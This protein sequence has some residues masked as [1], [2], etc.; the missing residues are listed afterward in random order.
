[1]EKAMNFFRKVQ[2][3]HGAWG[4]EAWPPFNDAN[5]TLFIFAAK[6]KSSEAIAT[7]IMEAKELRFRHE[8]MLKTGRYDTLLIAYVRKHMNSAVKNIV[9]TLPKL[10]PTVLQ[11]LLDLKN[12][13]RETALLVASKCHK[14]EILLCLAD[15]GCD[16]RYENKIPEWR[17]LLHVGAGLLARPMALEI[18]I[19][20]IKQSRWFCI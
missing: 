15:R 6:G 9:D 8:S 16:S 10:A 1:M 11:A 13:Q 7:M 3:S 5:E 2:Y 17:D 12:F 20:T 19:N 14:G 18:M 4:P